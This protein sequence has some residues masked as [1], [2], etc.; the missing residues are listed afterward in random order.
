V[1]PVLE[2]ALVAQREL[3]R[4]IRSVKGILLG[5]L[6]LLGSAAFTLAWIKIDELRRSKLPENLTPEQL[7]EFRHE[8]LNNVYPLEPPTA[9][10]LA[11]S[12]YVLFLV[13]MVTVWLTPL[14]VALLGF[15]TIAGDLQHRGVRYW[16]VRV[17]RWSYVLG[18]FFGL[19]GLMSLLTLVTHLLVWALVLIRHDADFA[20]TFS[21]GSRLWL[22]TL[23]ISGAWC[24]IAVLVSSLFRQPM[25][26]LLSTLGVAFVLWLVFFMLGAARMPEL[27]YG[28]PNYYDALLLSPNADRV[29]I[30]L[31]G[32]LGFMLASLGLGSVVFTQRDV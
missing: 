3:L 27:L 30:G 9:D 32:L 10:H 19:W 31:G 17:R 25:L 5:L 26:A 6:S 12:P 22:S 7:R 11:D 24:G 20:T 1:N 8:L 13:A 18:K 29:A 14:L 21:W 16:A 4:S 2:V 28:Y 15:D 23:P